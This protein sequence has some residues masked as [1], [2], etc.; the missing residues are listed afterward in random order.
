MSTNSVTLHRVLKAPPEKVFRAFSI[1][2]AVSFWFPPYGFLCTVH[3]MDFRQMEI[4][5]CHSPIFLQAMAIP[6]E[7]NIWR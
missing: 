5:E 7:A 2:E 1:P 4:I 3:K 6:L